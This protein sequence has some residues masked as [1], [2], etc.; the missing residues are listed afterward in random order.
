MSVFEGKSRLFN[1]LKNYN[2]TED[3][4][5]SMLHSQKGLCKI[6]EKPP[7]LENCKRLGK[8]ERFYLDIDHDHTTGKVRALL[9]KRCNTG[10]GLFREIPE[11]LEAA[12]SYLRS[13][14]E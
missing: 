3:D 10:I 12:A 8:N 9:C 4:Y 11:R 1:L 5:Y 7:S 13:F 14:S 2:L 6:C